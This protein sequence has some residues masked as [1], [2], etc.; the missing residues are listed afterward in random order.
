MQTPEPQDYTVYV[1]SQVGRSLFQRPTQGSRQYYTGATKN[2]RRRI[3]DHN[4]GRTT[5]TRGIEWE[6][7]AY[8]SGF[9]KKQAFQVEKYLKRGATV[10]K[11]KLFYVF[12]ELYKTDDT[13][14]QQYYLK[15]YP[16]IQR[17]LS[18]GYEG[19]S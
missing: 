18:R 5:A 15:V 17:F 6:I 12:A 16:S 8:L 14:A 9:T 7:V 13:A 11:R 19:W 1:L 2:L 10:E 3:V 4:E